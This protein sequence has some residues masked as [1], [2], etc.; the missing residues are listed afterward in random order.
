MDQQYLIEFGSRT[1]HLMSHLRLHLPLTASGLGLVHGLQVLLALVC[2]GLWLFVPWI[3][4]TAQGVQEDIQNLEASFLETQQLHTQFI[5]QTQTSGYSLAPARLQALP[6]EVK[7]ARQLSTQQRF[8]WTQFLND[9]EA[10][11]PKNVSMESV[12]LNFKNSSIALSGS[13]ASLKDLAALVKG[14]EDHDAFQNVILAGHKAQDQKKTRTKNRKQ[15]K[16][17]PAF[18]N[19]VDFSLEVTYQRSTGQ[20]PP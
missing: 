5:N 10:A 8:S 12:A 1:G 15:E 17:A 6:H 19:A 13:T 9:L 3:W 18:P 16:K 20:S 14:L 7:F 11:V 2:L 4:M